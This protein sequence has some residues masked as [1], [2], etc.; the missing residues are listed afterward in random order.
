MGVFVES[1]TYQ[2]QTIG[3][4]LLLSILLNFAA[5]MGFSNGDQV[6]EK[7]E[8]KAADSSV[9]KQGYP[10][11][12]EYPA[13]SYVSQDTAYPAATGYA[14]QTYPTEFTGQGGYPLQGFQ[15]TGVDRQ[16]LTNL[17]SLPM[18]L[19]A[20]A[21]AFLG[22]LV[23]PLLTSGVMQMMGTDEFRVPGIELPR[24]HGSP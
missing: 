9:N 10:V 11:E 23:A 19:T 12:A 5:L 6:E 16:S 18:I 15:Q 17:S 7:I 1:Q 13:T 22:S 21:A 4:M 14:G 3:K 2:Y 20:F 8:D 24:I